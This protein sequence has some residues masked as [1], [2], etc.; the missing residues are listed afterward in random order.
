MFPHRASPYILLASDLA[1]SSDLLLAIPRSLLLPC[2]HSSTAATNACKGPLIN[3]VPT[4]FH[5]ASSLRHRDDILHAPSSHPVPRLSACCCCCCCSMTVVSHPVFCHSKLPKKIIK[6]YKWM[7]LTCWG[8]MTSLTL[9]VVSTNGFFH[10]PSSL[11]PSPACKPS[12]RNKTSNAYAHHDHQPL[13]SHFK[14]TS[15]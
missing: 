15:G 11:T 2:R 10:M 5:K 12:Q 6:R 13:T 7:Q 3:L 9:G 14:R 8:I 4:S 1:I